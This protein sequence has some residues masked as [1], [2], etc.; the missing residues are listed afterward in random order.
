MFRRLQ[1]TKDTYIT[2]RVISNRLRATDANVGQAGT[3][4]LFKLYDESTLSG[5]TEPLELSRILLKA[6]LDPLRELTGSILDISH[7][8]FKCTLRLFD[9]NGG[10]TTPSNF[11]VILFPLS[12]SFDEGAGYD[13]FSFQDLD[14]ANF[15]TASVQ[16]NSPVPWFLTGANKEGLLGSDDIDII[17]SGNLGTGVVNTFVTQ[18]FD[19]GFEDLSMDITTIVSATLAGILPDEGFRLSFSGTQETDNKTR[20]VKRFATRHST[21][22]NIRPRIDVVFNDAIQDHHKSF[23]FDLSGSLFLNSFQRGQPANLVSGS[24]LTEV[25]GAD[26]VIVRLLSSSIS[27]S[28]SG[29]T[30]VDEQT[31]DTEYFS[32]TG[33]QHTIGGNAVTGV[34]SASFAIS[35]DESS[36]R[37]EI[38]SAGSGTF[39]EIWGSID[40]TVGYLT[41]SKSFVVKTLQRTSFNN[42]PHEYAVNV[43]G[44]NSVYRSTERV[45]FRVFVQDNDERRPAAKIPRVPE[46]IIFTKMRYRIRDAYDDTVIVGF[47]ETSNATLLSIDS[48]GMYFDFFMN[49]L[50]VG[51]VYAID[52]LVTE[53]GV[54]QTFVDVSTFRV[55]P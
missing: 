7:A 50:D 39:T 12:Q 17:S 4:D 8:S 22:A 35:S 42:V 33:S 40:G 11:S 36:L 48:D 1:V 47:E 28:L 10:Q 15:I 55:D 16:S 5:T 20:F 45:R 54:T 21:N 43:V 13:I 41:S 24:G 26:S 32:F 46:S 23:Y 31:V 27:Q 52:F 51:R 30:V 29:A 44:N 18:E 25:T 19:D 37:D 2:D 3:L 53:M 38:I 9:V 49:S 34:Y 14:S 6:D